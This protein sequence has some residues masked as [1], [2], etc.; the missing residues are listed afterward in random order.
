MLV[1]W[2][3]ALALVGG[4]LGFIGSSKAAITAQAT[5]M[6]EG[7]L[8]HGTE[9][10]VTI[11]GIHGKLV[12]ALIFDN[13][14]VVDAAAPDH[15][16]FSFKKIHFRYRLID[17]LSKRLTSR[18]EVVITEPNV[19]WIPKP[20]SPSPQLPFIDW[21][22][23]WAVTQRS[24]IKVKVERMKI[25][26]GP[27]KKEFTDIDLFY[28]DS[29]FTMHLPLSHLTVHESDISTV[30]NVEG[31]F[32]LGG[33]IKGD[34]LTGRITTEGT[35]INWKPLAEES[36][37][38]FALSKKALEVSA[39]KLLGGFNVQAAVLLNETLDAD[40]RV[41][42]ENYALSN[43]SAFFKA[44][45]SF[46][47]GR[48]DLEALFKG[49]LF[50]PHVEARLRFL[51]GS[52]GGR[53]FKVMDLNLS[54]VYPTVRL[55]QSR[56]MLEDGTTMQFADKTLEVH[57]LF[58]DKTLSRLIGES[59]QDTLVWGEWE[60]SRPLDENQKPEL[61]AE[62]LLGSRSRAYVKASNEDEQEMK[63][64]DSKPIE[65]GFEYRLR[66]KDSLKFNVKD[67]EEFVGVE[68]KM[69]F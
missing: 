66:S 65:A 25:L 37:V 63:M 31:R 41:R 13:V 50:E 34:K 26:Y 42:A 58:R 10:R 46:V 20:G 61:L 3:F 11:G 12:G 43:L 22:R 47:P 64:T 38:E 28:D 67:D 2:A 29:A 7:M 44:D 69:K 32:A 8:S 5:H 52:A 40:I 35:V 39:P 9:Y 17:L 19:V 23:D 59:Q 55:E 27:E 18:F 60:F 54:G 45:S 24:Q 33:G 48:L 14:E 49:P 51:E 56:I 21:M 1:E 57:E 30:L 15:M 16:R 62:R 68:H 53:N 4:V 36:T 6:L